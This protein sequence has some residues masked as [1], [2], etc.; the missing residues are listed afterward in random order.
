M[1]GC[2]RPASDSA[3]A[4]DSAQTAEA[5]GADAASAAEYLLVHDISIRKAHLLPSG[6]DTAE[7]ASGDEDFVC[8]DPI[9]SFTDAPFDSRLA[10]ELR[11][12]MGF[13][14]PAPVQAA[15]WP[16]AMGGF[17]TVVVAQTG[18]GKTIGYLLPIF[19]AIIQR[20]KSRQRREDSGRSAVVGSAPGGSPY[21][22]VLAPTR[23]LVVQIHE[24]AAVYGGAV[25]IT[26][27][28]LYGGV[29]RAGQLAGW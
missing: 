11:T 21:A 27:I 22:L 29:A 1:P 16:A 15:C 9:L 20:Q 5:G 17:D 10:R 26:S 12:T 8:P 4:V 3:A 25:G 6:D 7:P 2:K 14:A 28:A 19:D 18:S 24:Q 13:S 23:E